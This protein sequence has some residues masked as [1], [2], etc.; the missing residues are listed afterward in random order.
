MNWNH[1]LCKGSASGI[2]LGTAEHFQNSGTVYLF[3]WSAHDEGC[4]FYDLTDCDKEDGDFQASWQLMTY[5]KNQNENGRS[6]RRT[7]GS[8]FY[9]D[10]L[11]FIRNMLIVSWNVWQTTIALLLMRAAGYYGN[12]TC[13]AQSALQNHWKEIQKWSPGSTFSESYYTHLEV[14]LTTLLWWSCFVDI[15]C[16][17]WQ[18]TLLCMY[19]ISVALRRQLY[20]ICMIFKQGR[21][22][23]CVLS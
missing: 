11:D 23:G 17:V 12:T 8:S 18:Q 3:K 15:I 14:Y 19:L 9:S 2:L 20:L 4:C 1:P 13:V 10:H 6:T 5:I 16:L 7:F 22:L 21:S